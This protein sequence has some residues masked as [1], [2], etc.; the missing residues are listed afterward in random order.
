ML[1]CL[2]VQHIVLTLYFCVVGCVTLHGHCK[3]KQ[4]KEC[5]FLNYCCACLQ[6][7]RILPCVERNTGSL[8]IKHSVIRLVKTEAW[9]TYFYTYLLTYSMVQSPSWEA[10]WFAASQEI[11]RISR[12]PKVHYRT[13]KRPPPVSILGQPNPVPIPTSHLLEIRPNI[14]HPSTPRSPQWSVF[15][16]FIFISFSLPA[17]C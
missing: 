11:P 9:D 12:K 17:F 15:M 8:W 1:T 7:L 10:N 4:C 6:I 13:R 2:G 16:F 14:I 5:E 3:R